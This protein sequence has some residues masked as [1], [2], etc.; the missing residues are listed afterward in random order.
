MA[1]EFIPLNSAEY[2]ND[3]AWYTAA[4]SGIASG[5]LKVPEGVFSLAAELIDLGADTN[6][7]ASV[8]QFFDKLNPFEEIAEERA[9]GRLTE[10]LVQ[11][12]VPGA[13]GFKLA[14]KAARNLTA[15]ALRAKRANNYANLKSKNL[16]SAMGKVKDFNRKAKYGRFAAGIMGGAAGEAFVADTEKIGTFGD[17]FDGPTSL[18][19]EERSDDREEAARKLMNR[20]KFG[21]E[22]LLIT[23]FVYGA[24]KS[25]KLLANKGRDLAYSNSQFARW[26]DK[27]VR[28][29]FSPRGGLT[30][31]LFES[32]TLK[33]ALRGRD[34]NRAREIVD[35]ITREVDGIFPET[36]IMFDKSVR[37]EKD[38]FLKGLNEILF[39]GDIRAPID[40]QKV[41]DLLDLMKKSN[42]KEETRQVIVGGLNNARG[43]FNKLINIL[44]NNATGDKLS[45]GVKELQGLFKDR[46]TGWVG[47][48]YKIFET[49]KRGLFKFFQRYT[50]TDEAY[51]AAVRFFRQQIAKENGDIAF[52]MGSNKYTQEARAQVESIL[53]T[54][55]KTKKPKELGFNEYINKTMEG[56]PGA[57]F[58]KETIENTNAPP[59]EIRELLGEIQDPRYSI[60]NAM[61]NLSSVARTAAYLSDVAAK[62]DEVQAAGG[63]GFFWGSKEAGEKALDSMRTGI[64]LVPMKE[65][66]KELPG[67]G[68][69]VDPLSTKWTTKEIAEAIKN[70]NNLA[71]GLQGFVRGEGKEGAE[72]A[73][74]WFYR[75]L[76][77]FPKAISQLSK[78]VLSAPTHLRNF[79]SAFGFAGANGNLFEPKF[80]TSA[81][82]D[83]LNISGLT[84]FDPSTQAPEFKK[85]Y[86]ELLELGVVNQQVQIGDL[87]N[88]LRDVRFGEQASNIDT[89]LSPM[90]SKLK[91]IPMWAQ[92]KYVAEDDTFKI[93]SFFVEMHKLKRGYDKAGIFVTNDTLKKEA[94]DIVKNTVPNYSF[95][96]SA[97]RT[98]R[99]LPI[100]NFMS[101][102]SEMIRTTT[103]IAELGLKQ[104]RHSRPTRGSSVAPIVYDI[105]AGA[106]V[107]ND[108]PFY[109]D[110]IKRL[111]GLTTFVTGAPVALTE[112]AKALYDV[113]QDEL[114][115]LRRF[116]PEWSKNSTLIPVRD[117]ETGDL[118]YI[119]FSHSNAYDVIA[120]PMRT[121]L[122][123]IQ[124]GAANEE[125]LL[126]S[127]VDGVNEATAEIVNPFVSESIWTEAMADLTVRG[128]VTKDGR[129]LYTDQTPA[130]D[131]TAIRMMHA[132]NALAPSYKQIVRL[133]QA[134]TQTPTRTGDLLDVGP[135]IAG[136]MGLRPIKVNP[137]R[138]MDFKIQNYQ[139]GIRDA[140]REFT[141]G[142]FGLLKG[143]RVTVN[144]IINRFAKSNASRFNVQQTM[145]NDLQAAETLGVDISTLRNQFQDRQLTDKTFNDL[146]NGRFEPYFP[147]GDVADK[148]REIAN[149]L[150][151]DNPFIE[152]A[153][154]LRDMA[155]EMKQLSLDEPFSIDMDDFLIEDIVTPPLPES[156]TSAMPN[157][158][159]ITQGQNILNQGMNAQ[160]N[161]TQNGLTQI[162]NA[163]LSEE[164]KQMRLRQRGIIS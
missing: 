77:L 42:V 113:S 161:L 76:L 35:N 154:I 80:Y 86:R 147:S 43:E 48:T 70:A 20:I 153:P 83:G 71:G 158:K 13:I 18:D 72:Q 112:G 27:Y 155:L 151:E 38:K 133:Y 79:I 135:E 107:K 78:T 63:R 164:E 137:E 32:E 95:V 73:V 55:G 106:F 104:M 49:P 41:D 59:K 96:G 145:F 123:N 88:L 98:A 138:A 152:A 28:A 23:P 11:V 140:R 87:K 33:E 16:M 128:G 22:S 44:D 100:G 54:V 136:F 163:L 125:Q 37:T 118:R 74:S 19:R 122:N 115:A 102:P 47:G 90:M 45:K 121:L 34:I 89:V 58:I 149:N 2:D 120:R 126:K 5:I 160:A 111:V 97:V 142:A 56:R 159:T 92:G 143:G 51:T 40:S 85:L 17:M 116:V 7:A 31:E 105:E 94:A 82:K 10:A 60:F 139:T 84:K 8:E 52:D 114:D 124:D 119:D 75:N 30:Q 141:G 26:L 131:K 108:N 50:P 162:E 110:G 81:F 36:Q 25:A 65:I 61:T 91:K 12:G 46:I 157:N 156:V 148:F 99:L 64:E 68:K 29:P 62:N 127:F 39:E 132:I 103:N 66:T 109:G 4:A 130:G 57:S 9:I 117:E 53:N 144:D 67:A 69:I 6:T 146:K 21:S 3:T 129:R 101:F 14:N 24:G 134:G 1:E 93:A 15:K 150:G